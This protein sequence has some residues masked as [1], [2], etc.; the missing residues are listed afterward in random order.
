MKFYENYEMIVK[1]IDNLLDGWIYISKNDKDIK[2]SKFANTDSEE[3]VDEEQV[4]LEDGDEIPKKLYDMNMK[5]YIDTATFQDIISNA[6]SK[7]FNTIDSYIEAVAY[8]LEH[9]DFLE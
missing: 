5:R 6:K 3:D 1:D 2:T 4:Q 8:Y 9:D 7:G